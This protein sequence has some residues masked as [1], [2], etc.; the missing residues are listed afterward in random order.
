[1]LEHGTF[2]GL[3]PCAGFGGEIAEDLAQ[4]AALVL[5]GIHLPP[6]HMLCHL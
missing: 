1:M 2:G 5:E 4:T 6:G 3:Q